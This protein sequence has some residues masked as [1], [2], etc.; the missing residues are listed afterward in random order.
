MA[1]VSLTIP[2]PRAQAFDGLRA[3]AT[4]PDAARI[5]RLFAADP[6]RATRFTATLDDLTL[7]FSRTAIDDAALDALF[8]LAA[9]TGLDDFRRRLFAGEAV[10]VTEHRAAMHMA[11]RAPA[12]AGL[13]AVQGNGMEDAAQVAAAERQNARLHRGGA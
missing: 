1:P 4:R 3:L 2:D 10:N 7:D 6:S 12:S 13:R 11:L 8:A 9:S 5:M